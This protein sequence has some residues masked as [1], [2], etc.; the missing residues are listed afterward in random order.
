MSDNA[1]PIICRGL[2]CD[3]VAAFITRFLRMFNYG[4]LAPVFYLYLTRIGFSLIE[5][6]TMLT[7]ILCGDLVLTLWL[8][9][10]A[11]NFG[12]RATLMVASL[13][14]I[15]VSAST[16]TQRAYLFTCRLQAGATFAFSRNFYVLIAA[17]V[18]GVI[19][20]SGGEIGPF[21]AIEQ[22]CER[23]PCQCFPAPSAQ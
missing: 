21:M 3:G 7:A 15:L 17:G 9:T 8:S 23:A 20:T 10:R 16:L 14:K 11:D 12:R 2:P 4:A 19:S 6:G 13:L 18:V 22:A 5:S 1:P